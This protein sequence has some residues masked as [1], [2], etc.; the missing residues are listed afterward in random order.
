MTRLYLGPNAKRQRI[1]GVGTHVQP[2]PALRKIRASD[3]HIAADEAPEA[4]P[5]ERRLWIE[6]VFEF[7]ELEIEARRCHARRTGQ[8]RAC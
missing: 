4:L 5:E 6:A 3:F 7:P 2:R 8:F 1:A